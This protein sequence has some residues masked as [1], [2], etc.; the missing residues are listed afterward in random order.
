MINQVT[1]KYIMFVVAL[2]LLLTTVVSPAYGATT[3][4]TNLNKSLL[5]VKP[6]SKTIGEIKLKPDQWTTVAKN[7]YGDVYQEADPELKEIKSKLSEIQQPQMQSFSAFSRS[8]KAST[9]EV[10]S[11]M[12]LEQVYEVMDIGA[13]PVDVYWIEYLYRLTGIEPIDL[14]NRH[15]EEN[16]TWEQMEQSYSSK[17][18]ETLMPNVNEDVYSSDE[19]Q[20]HVQQPKLQA[21][22]STASNMTLSAKIASAIGD[23]T[24]NQNIQDLGKQEYADHA[25][26]AEDIST[27][28]GSLSW[29]STQIALPGRDGL[30][31]NI[32]IRYDSMDTSPYTRG[33]SD[34]LS[35]KMYKRSFSY[36][37]NDLGMG[38]SFQFPSIEGADI[39]GNSSR[40]VYHS[41]NGASYVAHFMSNSYVDIK[42]ESGTH[43]RFVLDPERAFTNGQ[44]KSYYYVEHIDGKKEYFS[45]EGM[46]IGETDRYGNTIKYNYQS[47]TVNGDSPGYVLSSI[48]DTL[49]R[50]VTF[51]YETTLNQGSE[52]QGEN[53]AVT[54]YNLQGQATQRVVY[55]KSRVQ[56]FKD[57][58]SDGYVPLLQSI[59]N[60]L[61][62]KQSFQYSNVIASFRFKSTKKYAEEPYF[63]L[64][65]VNY[66][67]SITHYS[68]ETVMRGKKGDSIEYRINSRSD[69]LLKSDG[70]GSDTVNRIDYTYVGDY[71]NFPNRY[72]N[73]SPEQ[74][75]YRYSQTAHIRSNTLSGD[76]T[77]TTTYS[78][79]HLVQSTEKRSSKGESI[80]SN[81]L[82]F[83]ATYYYNPT[84]TQTIQQDADGTITRTSENKYT[85]WGEIQS[86]TDALTDS[87][88]NNATT[89]AQHTVN[90]TYQDQYK[91]LTSK[92]WYQDANKPVSEKYTYTADGR[93]QSITNAAGETTTYSYEASPLN[94]HQIQKV[95]VSKPVRSGVTSTTT[96]A[97]GEATNYAYPT[98]QT[99]SITNTAKDGSKNT[100]VI[101][102]QTKY[103]MGTGLPT[104]QID[105]NG[106]ATIT[107]YDA[108]G[109][110]VK[111]VSPSITNLDG[112]TYAVED[113]Y[114]YTNRAYSTEADSTNAGILTM[115]VDAIRQ[116]TNTA[117]GAVTVL[118]RQS[119]YYD[120]FGFLRV[121]ETYN[122]SNGWTR[123]QYHPDDQGRAIYA[124]DPLG[125]TQTAS[126]DAWG[127]QAEATDP[128]GNLYITSNH[129]TQRKNN[130]FAIAAADI[131]AY[132][133][134][135]DNRSIRLNAVE[136]SYDV[137]GNLAT[138]T[139]F[140]DGASQSQPIQE[141]YTYDLQGNILSYTD[142][143]QTKNSNGVTSNYSYD[144]LNRLTAVQDGIDQTTRYA[145]DGTGG[146]TKITVND[147]AGK[148]ETLYTKAY[149][150]AGQLTDKTDTS[151]KNTA[152]SYSSRGL[153][154]EMRDRN[155]TITN[156][157]YDERGQRTVAT[158]TA[159][160]GNTLQTKTIFGSGGNILTDRHELYLNG[161]KTATQTSTID[162]QDRITSLTSTGTNQYSSRLDVAYDTL[163]R[164]TN[165]KNSLSGSSFFTNYGYD[166]LRLSQIQ[167]NGAQTRN[168]AKANNVNYEYT[169]LGM[170]QAI[171]FP[172]LADGSVLKESFTYDALNRLSQMSNTKGSNTLSAYSYTYDNNGNILTVSE[173]LNG[174]EAKTSTYTYDKL[175]RLATVKRIDG[176][177]ASYT[178][179]LRGNRKTLSDT[180]EATATKESSYSYDLD[181]KLIAATIDGTKTTIDYLPDGLRSQKTTGTATTQYGYNGSGQ[182]VSEKASNGNSSTYIR[183]D[184]VL[185]KKDQSASKDYY[186]LF[187]GHGDVVQMVDTSGAIVNSYRYDEWGNIAKQQETVANSFK[188]AG[189]A[190]DSETG[191]YYLKARYY[192]PSQ[193]RFLNEDSVE[194]QITN[195]LTLNI[196]GYVSNNPLRY[197]DPTGNSNFEVN[198]GTLNEPA[199]PKKEVLQDPT[200]WERLKKRANEVKSKA[201]RIN[202]FG[203]IASAIV[204]E[205]AK[206]D[207]SKYVWDKLSPTQ[208][209][210][211]IEAILAEYDYKYW[212]NI[213]KTKGGYFPIIDFTSNDRQVV[214]LKTI[215]AR[216]FTSGELFN[217]ISEDLKT[218]KSANITIAGEQV[219]QD[220]RTLDVR[221]PKGYSDKVDLEG[222]LQKAGDTKVFIREF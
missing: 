196:Y 116:Y 25:V 215:D 15:H 128:Y 16:K 118:S 171:T 52:F 111:I 24:E 117:T 219:S 123:S 23:V 13:E 199:K 28:T 182:V 51:D 202:I 91:L 214:S 212:Y 193:G 109:R 32:G 139:A 70:N 46:L 136:Q 110:P 142:P 64:N 99:Q 104:Q 121:D 129:M 180:Q 210:E 74:L 75:A 79:D 165:Q 140:K 100:Q 115:R 200:Y 36:A 96:T 103:D 56:I 181:N 53:I 49:G 147:S 67:R 172:T 145:Y 17:N 20:Y 162:K 41:S 86:Q 154:E 184:R 222:L 107:T 60:N 83:D 213:G 29:K 126:Y 88:F 135:A 55:T 14:W 47:R 35:A 59:T 152:N 112:T 174:G 85:D 39:N 6:P 166:K 43:L 191:L 87:D 122:E 155:G 65:Q 108:L 192:D 124:I 168:T 33:A 221:V 68:Y 7:V 22:T 38:W 217:K 26:D 54:V 120:G 151:G 130:H 95:I 19:E 45:A 61:Q 77:N 205:G 134:N 48:T 187:N 156:Y 201:K 143:N 158:L 58:V 42:A 63:L 153:V 144:A 178:Y 169:P 76:F 190:Y 206:N 10:P 98:E 5:S 40:M 167:T 92:S 125:N 1:Q 3:K 175:N 84:K 138:T 113:Q 73:G 66:P 57:G 194:G 12:S 198:P 146:L 179:D 27:S 97:Y 31:L 159:T 44:Y 37:R 4:S 185:V 81:N 94:A 176:S 189:E 21:N 2:V 204:E 11:E 93:P 131:S 211:M 105:S 216:L 195:P 127:Q 170:V 18:T 30:D 183:G 197:I 8:L 164:I 141:S 163:D 218:L 160:N 207:T 71:T 177:T 34:T 119:S 82:V 101:R 114:G 148:S 50:K 188:Y 78:G 9:T 203:E 132:R 173:S 133:A 89:K 102:Q 80:V 72:G 62:E 208:R 149:N 106:K 90:Y 161:T 69:Q 157:Q 137:Y 220:R 209:G 186:Y 150:E